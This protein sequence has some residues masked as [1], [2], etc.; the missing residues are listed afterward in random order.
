[1]RRL[2][3]T[4]WAV[5]GVA[6][7]LMLWGATARFV[8]AAQEQPTAL[9]PSDDYAV[10]NAVLGNVQFSQLKPENQVHALIVNDTLNLN[11][12]EQSQNPIMLN[13]CSPMLMPPATADDLRTML[14]AEFRFRDATWS[15]LLHQNEKSWRLQDQFKT[16]WAHG[17]TGTG[18]DPASLSSPE[19]K[20]P[21][22]AFYFSRVGFDEKRTEAIVFVFFASY[23]DRAPSSGDYFLVHQSRK[24]GWKI[25]GRM[26]YFNTQKHSNGN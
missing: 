5:S 1:M 10:Y 9:V 25:D 22:C 4:N 11:C 19:W 7:L 8:P 26:N 3:Q 21:D 13:N 14:A 16:S 12:G 23:M 17:L 18:V 15:D 20:T 6:T 2:A 24:A